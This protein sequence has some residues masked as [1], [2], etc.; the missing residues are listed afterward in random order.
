MTALVAFRHQTI[1]YLPVR[2]IENRKISMTQ[3]IPTIKDIF[4]A[5]ANVYSQLSPTPLYSYPTLNSLIGTKTW[6]KH[7]NHHPVGAFKVRGGLHL[8]ASLT[9]EEKSNGLFTASTGNHGQSIAYASRAYNI[10]A[11]IA[12]PIGAN[13][14]KVAAMKG[15][16][17]E[18]LFHW[19]GF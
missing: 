17:A 7:E 13:P 19:R 5:R 11:T 9:N 10:K 18:V 1:S 16:G 14:G 6:I 3:Q 8:A 2:L 4:A 12:V 15:L